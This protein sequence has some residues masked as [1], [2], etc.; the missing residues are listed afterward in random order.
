MSLLGAYKDI[1]SLR[2]QVTKATTTTVA[3][4]CLHWQWA[5]GDVIIH[6][7]HYQQPTEDQQ[8]LEARSLQL[9]LWPHHISPIEAIDPLIRS[10]HGPLCRGCHI[11]ITHYWFLALPLDNPAQVVMH[12]ST[13]ISQHPK[14]CQRK[15][16]DMFS[17][18][19]LVG[20]IVI[21]HMEATHL[22]SIPIDLERITQAGFG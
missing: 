14:C 13:S 16:L 3:N 20:L 19:M 4:R 7:Q 10:N 22:T 12:K 18:S 21:F 1:L 8:A 17:I 9:L 5:K 6:R 11:S 15:H 2:L